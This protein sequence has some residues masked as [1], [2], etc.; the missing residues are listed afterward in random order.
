MAKKANYE[1]SMKDKGMVPVSGEVYGNFAIRKRDDK[2]FVLDHVPSGYLV[3]SAGKK[4]E[5]VD[6]LQNPVF[7]EDVWASSKD[8]PEEEVAKLRC[9]IADFYSKKC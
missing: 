2:M 4:K 1:V 6:L 8:V 9:V 3:C 5:L 7:G